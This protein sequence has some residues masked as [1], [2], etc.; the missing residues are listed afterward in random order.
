MAG[1]LDATLT[2]VVPYRAA[3]TSAEIA[4]EVHMMNARHPRQAYKRVMPI[5]LVVDLLAH[6]VEPRRGRAARF[7]TRTIV[8]FREQCEDNVCDRDCRQII[9]YIELAP[10]L[11][12]QPMGW[13]A[14]CH[15]EALE[16]VDGV[17]G[18]LK[19]SRIDIDSQAKTARVRG[20][21]AVDLPGRMEYERRWT[22]GEP[23]ATPVHLVASLDRE[24]KPS[25]SGLL[26]WK[27]C[28]GAISGF[29]N[30]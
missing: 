4:G 12:G 7:E 9:R 5:K 14:A 28:A 26:G 20:A 19:R 1:E 25:P 29:P 23:C 10:Q 16:V 8:D 27:D 2:D 6:A 17:G 22:A 15:I 3:E 13:R 18:A 30:L 21:G 11:K 24:A